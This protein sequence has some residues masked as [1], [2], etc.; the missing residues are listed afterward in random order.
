MHVIPCSNPLR[1]LLLRRGVASRAAYHRVKRL[2]WQSKQTSDVLWL[3]CSTAVPDELLVQLY[4][5]LLHSSHADAHISGHLLHLDTG[6][7]CTRGWKGALHLGLEILSQRCPEVVV[8]LAKEFGEKHP[9]CHRF[10]RGWYS[11]S[12]QKEGLHAGTFEK[13]DCT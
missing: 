6:R 7:A 10:R 1:S 9:L 3:L 8:P 11:R 12:H 2:R 4:N 13:L 5:V